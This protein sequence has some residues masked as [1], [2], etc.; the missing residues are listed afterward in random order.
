[1]KLP[2]GSEEHY[3]D[4]ESGII[5]ARWHDNGIVAITSSEY[6]VSP[7]VKAERYVAS[8][9]KRMNVLIPNVIHQY[10]RKMG[11]VDRL[12]SQTFSLHSPL[13]ELSTFVWLPFIFLPKPTPPKKAIK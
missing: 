11:G 9:K 7:V 4:A 12:G 13:H 1:M 3:C 5:A 8:Q 6:G 10:N 2:R